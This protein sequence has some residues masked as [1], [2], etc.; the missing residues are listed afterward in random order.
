MASGQNNSLH[1]HADTELK[2]IRS[3][4]DSEI[5]HYHTNPDLLPPCDRQYCDSN[6]ND[7]LKKN[8]SAAAGSLKYNAPVLGYLNENAHNNLQYKTL[9]DETDHPNQKSSN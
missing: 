9:W 5:R 6:I 4:A 2:R 1:Q 3:L 7:I 8:P